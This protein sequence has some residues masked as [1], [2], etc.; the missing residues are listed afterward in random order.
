M[1]IFFSIQWTFLLGASRPSGPLRVAVLLSLELLL[2]LHSLTVNSAHLLL[3]SH[4]DSCSCQLDAW[5]VGYKITELL[6]VFG[7][8]PVEINMKERL[9]VCTVDSPEEYKSWQPRQCI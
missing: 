6:V 4:I 5:N 8:E 3:C 1:N 9:Q 2:F 7:A